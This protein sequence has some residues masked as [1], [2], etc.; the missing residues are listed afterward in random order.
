MAGKR[1]EGE[2]VA[3]IV[4]KVVLWGIFFFHFILKCLVDFRVVLLL[5]AGVR[6]QG[7]YVGKSYK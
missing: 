4:G 6:L 2:M 3:A 7:N 1:A 5:F